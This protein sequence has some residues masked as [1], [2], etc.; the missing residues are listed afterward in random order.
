MCITRRELL[1][2]IG[3]MT[4]TSALSGA[5]LSSMSAIGQPSGKAAG[6]SSP[7]E[8]LAGT[9]PLTQEGDLAAQMVEGIRQF[10]VKETAASVG[11]R[12]GLWHRDF[13]SRQTYETSVSRNRE[14]FR[15]V[16]GLM[17]NRV[18]CDAPELVAVWG[19]ADVVATGTA[20]RV[21][22]VRWPVLPGVDAEG[23]LLDP[24]Q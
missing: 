5:P 7:P 22:A 16:I 13:S 2:R 14:R 6:Y 10:L 8:Q 12:E 4:I 21:Y 24:S 23:L 1:Q 17:D 3:Q 19:D 20:Y 18:P 11:R 9:Q 15:R